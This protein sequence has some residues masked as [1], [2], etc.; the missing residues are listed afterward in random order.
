MSR[1]NRKTAVEDG[2]DE[3]VEARGNVAQCQLGSGRRS[4][5]MSV[6]KRAGVNRG[7]PGHVGQYVFRLSHGLRAG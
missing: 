6:P 4:F 1:P 5:A 7:V 3:K 2:D